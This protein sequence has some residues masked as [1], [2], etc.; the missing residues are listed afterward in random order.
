MRPWEIFHFSLRAQRKAAWKQQQ[1]HTPVWK[2]SRRVRRRGEGGA[3]RERRGKK[4]ENSSRPRER[5][6][7]VSDDKYI[8]KHTRNGL[9]RRRVAATTTRRLTHLWNSRD[10]RCHTPFC[11]ARARLLQHFYELRI[12]VPREDRAVV[13]F[14]LRRSHNQNE[15]EKTIERSLRRCRE[16]TTLSV[17]FRWAEFEEFE[18]WKRYTRTSFSDYFRWKSIFPP[19]QKRANSKRADLSSAVKIV[20]LLLLFLFP[21]TIKFECRCRVEYSFFFLKIVFSRHSRGIAIK[22]EKGI[23]NRAM[24]RR[25]KMVFF[26]AIVG[27]TIEFENELNRGNRGKLKR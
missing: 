9:E 16:R 26:L 15:S 20:S 19:S 4:E 11:R 18:E 22:F 2:N 14:F 7:F 10:S 8:S 25:V 1:Q 12:A 17:C 13:R 5:G 3:R 23:S 6:F 27:G 24:I 21:G